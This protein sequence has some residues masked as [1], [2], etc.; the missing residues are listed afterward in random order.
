M[1]QVAEVAQQ[2][3]ATVNETRRS[4]RFSN[5]S[6]LSDLAAGES[7]SDEAVWT[8]RWRE[9][10][11]WPRST[12]GAPRSPEEPVGADELFSNGVPPQPRGRRVEPVTAAQLGLADDELILPL[13]YAYCA[14]EL[15]ISSGADQ[16]QSRLVLPRNKGDELRDPVDL[17]AHAR[18]W[19]RRRRRAAA[20]ALSGLLE[21]PPDDEAPLAPSAARER[22]LLYLF[23]VIVALEWEPDAEDLRQ[24]TW[25]FRRA[26]DYLYDVSDGTLAFGQVIIGWGPAYMRAADIQI[27]ASNRMQGRAWVGGLHERSKHKPIRL[28]RGEWRRTYA[29][30]WDEPEGYRVIVHEWAHYA[31]CLRDAYLDRIPV[32][33]S[34]QRLVPPGNE[35]PDA[36]LLIPKPYLLGLSILETI[37]GVSELSVRLDKETGSS[38]RADERTLLDAL[39]PSARR[40]AQR[41]LN[42]PGSLPLPFPQFAVRGN[43]EPRAPALEFDSAAQL[44]TLNLRPPGA[45]TADPSQQPFD[46]CWL[47]V[48]STGKSA[49][50]RSFIAQGTLDI[51]AALQSF[52]L[53][54]A[55]ERHKLLAVVY[56]R[57][58]RPV[59]YTG[60]VGDASLAR[61]ATPVTP[62]IEVLP[63]SYQRAKAS[64]PQAL[65]ELVE[66]RVRL[67]ET[68]WSV[69]P[70]RLWICP[71]GDA[72]TE[73]TIDKDVALHE[74]AFTRVFRAAETE[75]LDGHVVLWYGDTPVVCAYSHGGN[76]P[77]HVPPT[78]V[79]GLYVDVASG[80]AGFT[81]V[82][83]KGE[84]GK[85]GPVPLVPITAGSYDGSV[86]IYFEVNEAAANLGDDPSSFDYERWV[87]AFNDHYSRVRVITAV[88]TGAHADA[89][90][91]GALPLTGSFCLT[92]NNSLQA[93]GVPAVN[94]SLEVRFTPPEGDMGPGRA[95]LFRLVEGRWKAV[96]T[97]S[98]SSF[99]TAVAAVL[100]A[101]SEL[102]REGFDLAEHYQ[103]WWVPQAS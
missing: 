72:V 87:Q 9:L 5:H 15:E 78:S 45:F 83:P 80:S 73:Y 20:A 33:R 16:R 99:G 14:F 23:N 59:T 38:G 27:A 86:R 77:R 70:D 2:G 56:N 35:A 62:L 93:H 37:D 11:W 91:D 54:G 24:L 52:R 6:T 49:A 19:Q 30:P 40:P 76:P 75:A 21:P 46:R 71:L 34:G 68:T 74:N 32:K 102:Y 12:R 103:L 48:Y 28:G 42:G 31:L 97:F 96:P 85:G 79:T 58:Q 47:Y 7:A 98:I 4:L 69:R 44:R 39:F 67:R 100:G 22:P 84:E 63:R 82:P 60:G 81:V 53:L 95:T 92:S 64:D 101:D 55:T 3:E 25:A 94:A 26:S 88:N 13:E 10:R 17:P 51:R 36:V 41:I 89:P 1:D 65:P 18:G 90:A 50:E 57:D 8:L 66:I 61:R 29:I 43:G